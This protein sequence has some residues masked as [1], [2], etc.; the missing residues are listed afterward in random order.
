M[1]RHLSFVYSTI[2]RTQVS[3][4]VRPATRYIGVYLEN[5]TCK[6]VRSVTLSIIITLRRAC[7]RICF[8][9]IEKFISYLIT[10]TVHVYCKEQSSNGVLQVCSFNVLRW[11][12]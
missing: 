3:R 12:L 7:A 6:H 9:C 4:T 8:H 2:I 11:L 5:L 10:S 1:L